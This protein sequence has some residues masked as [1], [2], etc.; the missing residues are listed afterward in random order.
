MKADQVTDAM[1]ERFLVL[2]G[3]SCTCEASSEEIFAYKESIAAAY[4]AVVADNEP[5]TAEWLVSLGFVECGTGFY[6]KQTRDLQVRWDGKEVSLLCY[7]LCTVPTKSR[8]QLL[9]LLEGLGI[10]VGK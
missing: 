7:G 3:T 2:T 8:R 9:A 10:E 5:I 6:I 1:V 4:N